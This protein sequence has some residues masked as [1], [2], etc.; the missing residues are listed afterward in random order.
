ML[1]TASCISTLVKH[2]RIPADLQ[3]ELAYV[4]IPVPQQTRKCQGIVSPISQ[5]GRVLVNSCQSLV[6]IS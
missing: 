4:V 5:V 1:K 6:D 2:P 3:R